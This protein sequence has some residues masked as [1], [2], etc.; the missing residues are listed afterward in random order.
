MFR[1]TKADFTASPVFS[2]RDI[3]GRW[4]SAAGAPAVSVYRNTCR[5]SG[6]F[7]LEL[8]YS[9]PHAV[10]SRPIKNLFGQYYI[11]L[12]G[13]LDLAY[14]AERELLQLSSYGTY[15]RAD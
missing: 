3:S 2:L 12:Y 14:D 10:F 11:N 15:E 4:K 13:R 8:R 7:W 9:H 6:G 1:E 5:K